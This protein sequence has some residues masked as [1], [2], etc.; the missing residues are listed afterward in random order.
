[1]SSLPLAPA[2]A[3]VPLYVLPVPRIKERALILPHSPREQ[4]T[5]RSRCPSCRAHREEGEHRRGTH[6]HCATHTHINTARLDK[7]LV[8]RLRHGG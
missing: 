5:G 7:S 2:L 1:M 4:N 3:R 6:T 8:R